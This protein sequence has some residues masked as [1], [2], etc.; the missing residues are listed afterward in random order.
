MDS[1]ATWN[2]FKWKQD[3]IDG[4]LG[5]VVVGLNSP[6]SIKANCPSLAFRPTTP[7]NFNIGPLERLM[8][9]EK[10]LQFQSK[11]L[12]TM[13]S[14]FQVS[15]EIRDALLATKMDINHCKN[16]AKIS[17]LKATCK[18][19]VIL[20]KEFRLHLKACLYM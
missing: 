3:F 14:H 13:A 5:S 16:K 19:G 17:N 6:S 1:H 4:R 8:I 15:S 20:E 10:M 2:M 11:I 12:A 9:K 18:L 7:P